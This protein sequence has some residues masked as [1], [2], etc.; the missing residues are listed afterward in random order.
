MD[1]DERLMMVVNI[2]GV[3]TFSSIVV[4]HMITATQKDAE[5]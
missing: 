4:Y 5:V 3:I 1:M 2:L